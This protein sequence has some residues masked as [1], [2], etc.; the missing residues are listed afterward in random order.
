MDHPMRN[1]GYN[2]KALHVWWNRGVASSYLSVKSR[3]ITRF[4]IQLL[5]KKH[6]NFICNIIDYGA[7][8]IL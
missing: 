2:V 4:Q 7:G 3:K 1:S 8:P 6:L 5:A